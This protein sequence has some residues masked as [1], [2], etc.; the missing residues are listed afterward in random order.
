MG[1]ATSSPSQCTLSRQ[2]CTPPPIPEQQFASEEGGAPARWQP[3]S[4]PFAGLPRM[5]KDQLC[6]EDEEDDLDEDQRKWS[7]DA[8]CSDD[9]PL[10]YLEKQCQFRSM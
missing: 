6:E 7:T 3:T 5:Q 1:C 10:L 8:E 4:N 2:R 9:P